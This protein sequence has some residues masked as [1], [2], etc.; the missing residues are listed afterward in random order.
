MGK[1]R[2]GRMDSEKEM[3][4]PA[5]T[6]GRTLLAK[7]GNQMVKDNY[8]I[9]DFR[10]LLKNAGIDVGERSLRRWMTYERAHGIYGAGYELC[11]SESQVDSL[12]LMVL[13]GWVLSRNQ[14]HSL[15]SLDAVG[16]F[17]KES[18]GLEL[19]NKSFRMHLLG[20]GVDLKYAVANGPCAKLSEEQRN[21]LHL[22]AINDFREKGIFDDVKNLKNIACMDGTYTSMMKVRQKG[23]AGIGDV[24]PKVVLAKSRFT[25]LIYTLNTAAGVVLPSILFTSDTRFDFDNAKDRSELEAACDQWGLERWQVQYIYSKKPFT[26]ECTDLAKKAVN[27]WTE[28]GLFPSCRKGVIFTDGS[29]ATKSNKKSVLAHEK[30]RRHEVFPAAA[31]AQMSTNDNGQHQPA[32]RR[33]RL[34]NKNEEILFSDEPQSSLC[35]LGN[36]SK[37]SPEAVKSW[38]VRNFLLNIPEPTVEDVENSLKSSNYGFEDYHADCKAAFQEFTGKESVKAGK[39]SRKHRKRR[40]GVNGHYHLPPTGKRPRFNSKYSA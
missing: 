26:R 11:G 36:L 5:G 30:G 8:E 6:D 28:K 23:L 34:A 3:V 10:V 18:L 1:K 19:T 33:W 39:S 16:K 29:S 9:S 27:I 7:I 35:L 24:S 12:D 4:S 32:K 37:H 38:W 17:A 20:G 2:R 13:V 25:N 15:V 40:T 22:N 31:H 21:T 14:L